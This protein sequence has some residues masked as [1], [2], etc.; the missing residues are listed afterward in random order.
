MEGG[1]GSAKKVTLVN[2]SGAKASTVGQKMHRR[3]T[4][5]CNGKKENTILPCV[6]FKAFSHSS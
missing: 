1:R 5:L 4:G 6:L 2:M 3:D